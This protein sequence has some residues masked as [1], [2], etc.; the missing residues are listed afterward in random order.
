MEPLVLDPEAPDRVGEDAELRRRGAATR[1]DIL[2]VQ[3][4]AITHPDLLRQLLTD[5]RVSKDASA[6]WPDFERQ[7]AVWPL[8]TWV[9]VKNM[10]TAY[11]DDHRRLRR[12]IQGAFTTRQTRARAAMVEG[13]ARQLLD[14]LTAHRTDGPVDLRAA[15][16]HP[17]PILTICRLMGVGSAHEEPLRRAVDNVFDTTLTQQEQQ[18]SAEALYALLYELIALKRDTPGD[19]LISVLIAARGED[20]GALSES[21]LADT[22]LLVI[23]A[24][25]ETTVALITNA[26]RNL[27]AHP[28]QLQLVREGRAAFSDVV[29]ETLRRDAPIAHLPMRFAVQDLALPDGTVIRKGEAILAAYSAAGRHPETYG[30]DADAFDVRRQEKEHLAFGHGVHL[31]LG[32]PLARLEATTALTLLFDRFP[33]IAPAVDPRHL[34]PAR[35]IISNNPRALPVLL[36]PRNSPADNPA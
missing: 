16:A 13:I 29:E 22:L 24:G 8:A 26:V 30:P 7:V 28:G 31:C 3:A 35:S 32:A 17:L 10:F 6:H 27:L 2:G 21:E 36:H 19:D 20:D 9:A 12:L 14:D 15:F 11:G 23:S 4:W 18:T 34:E 1:V 33:D 5:P 25:F